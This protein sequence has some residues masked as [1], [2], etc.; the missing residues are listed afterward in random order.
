MS[1]ETFKF[2]KVSFAIIGLVF[3]GLVGLNI[4]L[5]NQNKTLKSEGKNREIVLKEGKSLIPL[6]GLDINNE[7]QKIEWGT[8]NQKTLIMI[9]SPQCG[10]CH[11]NMPMWKEIAGKINKTDFRTVAV[12]SFPNGAKEFIEEYEF[13]NIPIVI[14]PE[15]A[16]KVEYVMYL[17]PQTVLV[18][19]AGQVEKVWIGPIKDNN[20]SEIEKYLNIKLETEL[21]SN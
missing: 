5:I 20:K 16:S 7:K 13:S 15:P 8:E 17:T 14:E 19:Q 11:E 18:N 12:S 2:N 3:L 10:Y 6:Q 21:A 9:F 1:I 4:F